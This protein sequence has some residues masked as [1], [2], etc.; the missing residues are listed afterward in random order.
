MT[1]DASL[2][3]TDNSNVSAN[4]DE[5]QLVELPSSTR[6]AFGFLTLNSSGQQLLWN[7]R[8]CWAAAAILRMRRGLAGHPT[9]LNFAGG[10]FGTTM[11]ELDGSVDTDS[12]WGGRHLLSVPGRD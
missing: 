7:R 3:N 12:E 4:L 9:F 8:C 5:K 1:A 6:N 10:F 2:L 11:F